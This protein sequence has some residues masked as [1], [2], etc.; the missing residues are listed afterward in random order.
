MLK[1]V[2]RILLYF[3]GFLVFLEL[4][5]FFLIKNF[6]LSKSIGVKKEFQNV[7][8]L[9]KSVNADIESDTLVLGD[10]VGRQLYPPV[11]HPSFVTATGATLVH[12]NHILL[13]R[14]HKNNPTLKMVKYV[15][16]PQSL[17]L[18]LRYESVTSSYVKPF[19]SIYRPGDI[20]STVWDFLKAKPRSYA[21]L[22]NSGKFLPQDDILF[23][24]G[25]YR[26]DYRLSKHSIESI[27]TMQEYCEQY[28]IRFMLVSPPVP[29][30]SS[31]KYRIKNFRMDLKGHNDI[32]LTMDK[33]LNSIIFLPRNQFADDLHFKKK[34][35]RQKRKM[36]RKMMDNS[37]NKQ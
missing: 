23:G 14:A 2:W 10:S 11:I 28:G 24:N 17:A 19:L 26:D 16:T 12:G 5:S 8:E 4:L 30:L 29:D 20:T 34:D 18:D 1:F 15:I 7:L 31:E 3:I 35:I 13:R 6:S 21:Y 9:T 36:I 22:F 37:Y 27:R 32:A 33:Y 25:P